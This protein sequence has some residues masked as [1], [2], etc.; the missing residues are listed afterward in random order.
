[1]S[2]NIGLGEKSNM[3][4]DRKEAVI[5]QALATEAGREALAQAMVEPI[6]IALEYQAVGRKLLMVDELSQGALARYERDIAAVGCPK[7]AFE[8]YKEI[9]ENIDEVLNKEYIDTNIL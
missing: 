8:K 3:S 2:L 1:M 9:L 7:N 4:D 6:K 5:A